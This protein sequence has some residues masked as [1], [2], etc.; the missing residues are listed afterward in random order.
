MN[1]MERI[2]RIFLKTDEEYDQDLLRAYQKLGDE[3]NR[4]TNYL[5]A[6]N[7]ITKTR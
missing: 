3:I 7:I 2:K 4:T 1:F 5:V 6:P